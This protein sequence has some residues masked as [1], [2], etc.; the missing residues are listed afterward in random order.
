MLCCVA[1]R[2]VVL[3]AAC[4]NRRA[5]VCV[6]SIAHA[7]A[8]LHLVHSTAGSVKVATAEAQNEACVTAMLFTQGSAEGAQC[9]LTADE[10]CR[11]RVWSVQR[12]DPA[13]D[14]L[15]AGEGG[16]QRRRRRGNMELLCEHEFRDSAQGGSAA[17]ALQWLTCGGGRLEEHVLLSGHRNGSVKIWRL[18]GTCLHDY[19]ALHPGG[20]ALAVLT[21]SQRIDASWQFEENTDER[22]QSVSQSILA[23]TRLFRP[24]ALGFQ[25]TQLTLS[26]AQGSRTWRVWPHNCYTTEAG[27]AAAESAS[28]TESLKL[29]TFKVSGRF[30]RGCFLY[31]RERASDDIGGVLLTEAG[32][33]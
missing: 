9:L 27:V 22:A 10:Q 26:M 21:A 14:N 20:A 25:P 19:P 7:S 31:P 17:S 33:R 13:R 6:C 28:L 32:F 12:V 5:R 8:S 2:D 23:S 15:A 16:A 3:T 11:F 24:L 1:M 18:D 4:C 30:A 29:R